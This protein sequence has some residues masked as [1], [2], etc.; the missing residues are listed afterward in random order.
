MINITPTLEGIFAQVVR[1]AHDVFDE[2]GD[3]NDVKAVYVVDGR[4]YT[5]TDFEFDT[6]P[7]ICFVDS[8]GAKYTVRLAVARDRYT[9]VTGNVKST[10]S[11]ITTT[12]AYMNVEGGDESGFEQMTDDFI[13]LASWNSQTGFPLKVKAFNGH[14]TTDENALETLSKATGK[15]EMDVLVETLEIFV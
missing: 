2:T 1:A 8:T 4:K 5:F 11:T 14:F 3:E 13:S 10:T 6:S 9:T 7:K 12:V 15:H